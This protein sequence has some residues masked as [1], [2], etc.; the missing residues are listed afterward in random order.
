MS[1]VGSR[2][3][4][5]RI[6]WLTIVVFAATAAV[7]AAQAIMPELLPALRRQ[8]AMV[9]GQVWRFA[10]A[11][12]VHDEG[13]KQIAIN[14][15]LLAVA[16]TMAEWVFERYVWLLAYALAGL[17]GEVAGLFWQPVGAGNSVAI[18]GLVGL[19]AGWWSC[20]SS[21]P[22]PQRVIAA[23][24]LLALAVWLTFAHDIHGPALLVGL[25]LGQVAMRLPGHAG[26]EA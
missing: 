17:A 10:T 18:L 23:L 9:D 25:L 2:R 8:P 26:G 12:L 5:R 11:W 4:N 14:F 6:P 7:T 15:P 21:V 1:P 19:V 24:A 13:F 16:G 3:L 20:L 22:T